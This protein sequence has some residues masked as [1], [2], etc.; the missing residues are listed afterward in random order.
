V[1][2]I[3]PVYLALL[4]YPPLLVGTVLAAMV[5]GSAFSNLLM[6]KYEIRVGTRR[7]L[8]IFSFLIFVS[9]LL[10]FLTSSFLVVIV[11]SFIGN[12]STTG[13]EAG[14]FQSVESAILPSLVSD[15]KQNRSFGVYNMVGY[16]ASSIGA[17][18]ARVPSYFQNSLTVFRSLYL[19][20]AFAGIVLLVLYLGLRGLDAS[21][22][23]EEGIRTSELSQHAKKDV[24][25]LSVLFSI[26]SFGGGFV[27]QSLLVYWFYLTYNVSLGDLG[28]IFLVVNVIT[29]VSTLAAGFLAD[30]FGNLRTMVST[31]LL[32][33]IH[34]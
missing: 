3:T 28:I 18:A 16:G 13:A 17:F 22:S 23:E 2:I 15:E 20:Y 8:L 25:K 27:S 30:R 4:G 5:T 33:L 24:A 32:S 34:I 10:F 6:V 9:G 7:F 19:V 31:H 1:S 29:A 26:D 11:A 21:R 12:I 14:P